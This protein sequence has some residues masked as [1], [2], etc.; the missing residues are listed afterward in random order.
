MPVPGAQALIIAGSP[1]KNNSLPRH[2]RN[3]ALEPHLPQQ[4]VRATVRA[5]INHLP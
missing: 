5:W 2:A 1:A 3:E 4:V